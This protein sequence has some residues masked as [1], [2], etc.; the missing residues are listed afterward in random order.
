[1][2]YTYERSA[3]SVGI[4]NLFIVTLMALFVIGS[5]IAYFVVEN[6]PGFILIIAWILGLILVAALLPD[7]LRLIKSDGKWFVEINSTEMNWRTPDEEVDKSFSYK[8]KDM[9]ATETKKEKKTK[10][11]MV[12][13]TIIL[14]SSQRHEIPQHAGINIQRVIKAL[15]DNGIKNNF[16]YIPKGTTVGVGS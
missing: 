13:Y 2:N 1:M 12:T 9:E 10:H 16:V 3:K 14:K 11:T 5:T 4:R 8:L 6:F 15:E 7:A